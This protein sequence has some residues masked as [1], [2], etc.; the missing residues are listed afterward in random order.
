MASIT[1]DIDASPIVS[2][3]RRQL[4]PDQATALTHRRV[5]DRTP[6]VV[7]ATLAE[8]M[9]TGAPIFAYLPLMDT[10]ET[11]RFRRYLDRYLHDPVH[12]FNPAPYERFSTHIS[13][14]LACAFDTAGAGPEWEPMADVSWVPSHATTTDE[15]IPYHRDGVGLDE[16]R[17]MW[18]AIPVFRHGIRGGF[19]DLP[20]YGAVLDSQDAWLAVLP[21]WFV[22]G[23]TTTRITRDDGYR[24]SQVF[25]GH[26]G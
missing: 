16:D 17:A 18:V 25:V 14:T 7:T 19:L 10:G 9:T 20:E 24:Y 26:A 8:D 23:V 4:S 3:F 13:R 11:E 21:H 1:D 5:G 2:L 22:H 15:F 12:A 6:T